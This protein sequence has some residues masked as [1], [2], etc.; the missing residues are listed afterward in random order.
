ME[1]GSLKKDSLSVLETVALSVAVMGPSASVSVIVILMAEIT[2]YSAP[3]VLFI[4]MLTVGLVAVS[5]IKLNQYFPSS[6]SVYGFA[7]K[8]LGRKAGFVAG[9]LIVFTYLILGT[10]CA[11]IVGTYLQ[12]VFGIFGANIH[13]E[14]IVLLELVLVRYL[15]G[16]DAKANTRIML[17]LEAVTMG[18]LIV[19]SVFILTKAAGTASLSAA[20]FMPGS[21][22]LSAIAI[23]TVFGFLAFSGFEGASSLGEESKNPRKTIPIAVASAVVISGIFYILVSYAQVIG[24][25][26][27]PEGVKALVG[28]DAPM[29]ELASRYMN[30]SYSIIILLCIS[31]SFFS[32]VLGCVSAGARI[33]YT[34]GRDGLLSTRL[35][36]THRK[37]NTPYVGINILTAV[38]A[39]IL[40]S[41]FSME[42]ID[43][44]RYA[45]TI[46]TLALILTYILATFCALVFFFRN[47][48]W[49]GVKLI[50]PVMSIFLLGYIFYSNVYPVPNYPMNLFPYL[51]V[52]WIF[53]G[54]ILSF[55]INRTKFE[56]PH[57][58]L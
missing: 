4:S 16:K 41:C 18:I 13:W 26:A 23:A 57:H 44:G 31:I 3:L 28:S 47:N 56:N 48:I 35:G 40:I 5:I 37:Y 32:A 10:S 54:I 11:T 53:V 36:K 9:W 25:G 7:E 45:A 51:V 39:L 58:H 55:R 30:N 20:P 22:S 8:T 1:T 29:A 49:K 43:V 6:G 38:T 12:I 27:T 34:M 46:G 42:A 50:I 33:L 14:P 2:V 19:L 17:L 15:T 52:V 24:F 21:N